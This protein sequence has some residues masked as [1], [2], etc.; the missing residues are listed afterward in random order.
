[1][2]KIFDDI[3]VGK[4]NLKN[5]FMR[6]ATAEKLSDKDGI[7]PS[8][9]KDMYKKL[10][11]GD[12]GLI[13]TGHAY[14]DRQGKAHSKMSAIDRDSLIEIWHNI[15]EPIKQTDT[16]IMMQINHGGGSV[17]TNITPNPL[18][19]SG[20]SLKKDIKPQKLTEHQ[21]ED[22]INKFADAALRVKKAGFDGVQIHAAHGY[23][24]NQFILPYT[25]K[26]EDNWGGE[27]ENRFRIL[28]EII[29]TSREKVGNEFPIWIKLGVAGKEK[30]GLNID[31]GKI[32][33]KMAFQEGID[34]IEISNAA[35]ESKNIKKRKSIK[36]LPWAVKVRK[37]V[38]D[39]KDLA[40]VNGFNTLEDAKN[41]V[42]KRI[43][44]LVS[45][46]RPLIAEP[47]LI[48]K[49]K[50]NENY[51]AKCIRCNQCWPDEN[52]NGIACYN[53]KVR[54]DING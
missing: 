3:T 47:N 34:C 40:L 36:Y 33:A 50:E 52:Q 8:K 25:N 6:S 19:P 1:M 45:L 12:I 20:I 28:K 21:I 38:G 44:D 27:I 10:A 37:E 49:F 42:G 35:S 48:S 39:D 17:D 53:K 14:V 46:C 30:Y 26:R 7:P 54:K 13:V 51:K 31:E 18:S 15:I 2:K 16:K 43:T 29:K 11:E 9:L 24:I 23:L 4:L 5:R 32:F 41:V 22:I